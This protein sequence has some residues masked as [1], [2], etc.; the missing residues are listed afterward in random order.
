M[1]FP[2]T[3]GYDK[4][5]GITVPLSPYG[6]GGTGVVGTA[7]P[8]GSVV[9]SDVNGGT[10]TL[11]EDSDSPTV[12]R[13]VQAT[14][15]H[16]FTMGY[17]QA[18]NL[19][20]NLPMGTIIQDSSGNIWRLLT[21]TVQAQEGTKGKLITVS[22][23]V[24]FDTPP[25]EFQV[26]TVDLGID[27]IKHPRYFPNLYPTQSELGTLTGQIKETIIRAIQT[28]RDSPFFPTASTLTGLINGQVQNIVTGGLGNGTFVITIKNPNYQ[29]Q[30][31]YVQDALIR[32]GAAAITY[33]PAAVANG[34]TNDTVIAI[35]VNSST[36]NGFYNQ[37]SVALAVAAA[38]EIITK[39]WRMED[40]PYMA[41]IEV[42]WGQYFFLPPLFDLGS[43]LSDPTLI[44]PNYFLQPDRPITE[45]PPRGGITYPPAGSDNIFQ[46]NALINPQDYSSNGA[47]NG[48][49]Q[50]SWL[51]KA[52]EIEYQRTWFKITRTW[53]GSAIGYF[54]LQLYGATNRPT[55]PTDYQTFS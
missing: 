27:I 5:E 52:D 21:S 34:D 17:T 24:S 14:A 9:I 55:S 39:L 33:T 37:A 51:R 8:A 49:T 3:W 7:P 16:K 35:S 11:Q 4:G 45:L 1:G 28:Y 26:N 32:D 13:G 31:N 36:V 15:Q 41:G 42:K 12:E 50:I 20:A 10:I 38:Q 30:F 48:N 40:S 43:Y 25:D 18:V 23:S 54:D 44:V 29:P 46:A 2:L 6:T 47:T 22:E 53:V 19:G